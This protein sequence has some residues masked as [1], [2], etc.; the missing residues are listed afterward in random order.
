MLSFSRNLQFSPKN[1]DVSASRISSGFDGA[2]N[3]L[4]FL[5]W[6]LAIFTFII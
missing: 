4:F 2:I 3:F 5:E 1:C 6:L